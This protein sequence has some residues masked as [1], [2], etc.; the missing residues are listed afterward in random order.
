MQYVQTE[1]VMPNN[2][3]VELTTSTYS[4]LPDIAVCWSV[5]VLVLIACLPVCYR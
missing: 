3:T 1:T 5:F 4:H 2:Y